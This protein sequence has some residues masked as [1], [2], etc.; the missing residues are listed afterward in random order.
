LLFDPGVDFDFVDRHEHSC[1][2]AR[3]IIKGGIAYGGVD[4]FILAGCE[5]FDDMVMV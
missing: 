5:Y 4:M 3:V 1:S 2:V